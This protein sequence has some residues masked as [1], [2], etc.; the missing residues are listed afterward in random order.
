[1]C[2]MTEVKLTYSSL[3]HIRDFILINIGDAVKY[4]VYMCVDKPTRCSGPVC[5]TWTQPL[6]NLSVW[7]KY[8]ARSICPLAVNLWCQVKAQKI[9][10]M[11]TWS[12]HGLQIKLTGP[13]LV[14]SCVHLF[15]CCLIIAYTYYKCTCSHST[16][17]SLSWW[18]NPESSGKNSSYSVN[19]G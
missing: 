16:Q 15:K 6:S 4:G 1:M 5:T 19:Q 2:C 17:K 3:I 7:M 8:T 9:F 13:L 11:Q 14:F 18:E 10:A 12:Q